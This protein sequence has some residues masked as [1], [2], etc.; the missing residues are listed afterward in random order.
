[1][2]IEIRNVKSV[3]CHSLQVLLIGV[4]LCSRALAAELTPIPCA[5]GNKWEY[6]TV[7][8]VRATLRFDGRT[9]SA[10]RD[11]SYGS[12]V[13]EVIGA[14]TKDGVPVYDYREITRTWSASG[15]DTHSE[16]TELK[17]VGENG[18]LRILS[19][20]TESSSENEPDKQEYDPPLLYFSAAEAVAAKS[21]NVGVMRERETKCTMS[22]RGVGRETVIV[23]A[24]TFA[25]CLKVVYSGD[26]VSGTMDLWNK[27]FTITGGRSCGVYWIAEGIGVVKELEVATTIAETDGPGGEKLT[28]EAASC[29]V[30]EL[31]PG[32]VIRK[33]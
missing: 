5:V 18:V 33:K 4:L 28:L 25:D 10:F 26:N 11:A 6:D 27:P 15:G 22:A 23:P 20:R 31:K 2:H 30:S 29:T 16:T 24:G 17:I 8:L 14:D 13:Y 32:Y 7:K 21:W 3:I 9:L 19:S 1:M 12:S